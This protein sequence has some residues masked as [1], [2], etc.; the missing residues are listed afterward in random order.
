MHDARVNGAQGKARVELRK[1][2]EHL[3]H[4][5]AGNKRM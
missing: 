4:D 2:L 1:R 3:R 5:S